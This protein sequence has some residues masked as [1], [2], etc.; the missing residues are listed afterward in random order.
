MPKFY[1]HLRQGKDLI[2]DPEGVELPDVAAAHEEAIG[3]AREIMA[4]RVKVGKV[5]NGEEFVICGEA[6]QP[7]AT[8]PFKAALHL[9]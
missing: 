4:D 6:G 1:F 7:I 8:I 5:V 3:A 9:E 2:E